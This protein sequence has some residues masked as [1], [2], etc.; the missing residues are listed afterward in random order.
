MLATG[1]G[2]LKQ[3][4]GTTADGMQE[5]FA[6]NLFGHFLLVSFISED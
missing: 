6:T 4:D 2:I 1:A 3:K 5:I